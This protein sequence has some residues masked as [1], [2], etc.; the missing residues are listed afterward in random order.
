MK[1]QHLK[2]FVLFFLSATFLFSC[3]EEETVFDNPIPAEREIKSFKFEAFLPLSEGMIKNDS[4]IIRIQVP[5]NTNKTNLTP[6]IEI[7][8]GT[9]IEP[10]S[11][12][13]QNFSK[14]VIYTVT[15]S[16]G[17]ISKYTVIVEDEKS[18][19]ATLRTAYS[20]TLFR[21]AT[22]NESTSEIIFDAGFGSDVSAVKVRFTGREG[23]S[24]FSPL[25]DATFDLTANPKVTVTAPNGIAT[26]EYTIKA[27]ILP[28][29][30]GIRGV[31]ITNVD[32]DVLTSKAKIEE[33]VARCKE[34]NFN[35][36]FMVTYNK[37]YTMY[38]SQTMDDLFDRRIDPTYVGRNPLEEMIEAAHAEN[39][40]VFAWFEYGFAAFNGSPGP[41]LNKFPEWAA[42]NV[43]GDQ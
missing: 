6:T 17:E 18:N 35:A 38:P 32:S 28:Q 21:T 40:K 10:A 14:F 26:K 29:E 7:T 19:D 4:G 16:S 2:I 22:I 33:A 42:I 36:I 11:G 25:S 13:A 41:I 20:P 39:I 3:D 9:T 30:T 8:E 24:T 12:V 34:L 15:A 23:E 37:A 31:W 43:D 5:A 1:I 27:N